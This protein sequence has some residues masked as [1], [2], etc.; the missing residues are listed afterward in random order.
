M[1]KLPF[2][3]REIWLCGQSQ[4]LH[5]QAVGLALFFWLCDKAKKLIL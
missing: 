3:Q 1:K 4:F 2:V 5:S